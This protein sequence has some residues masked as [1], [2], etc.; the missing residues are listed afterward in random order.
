MLLSFRTKYHFGYPYNLKFEHE[1][2]FPF[3]RFSI[4]NLGDPFVESNYGVHS[5]MFEIE[6]LEFYA[7]LWKI[8]RN[9][10]FGYVTCSGT[11]GNLHGLY[12]GR[13]CLNN[14]ILYSSVESHYSVFKAARFYKIDLVPIPTLKTGEIN[15]EV[16]ET[17]L[18][19]NLDR[20]VLLNANVG[21]TMKGKK[22]K[23]N[24]NSE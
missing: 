1:E 20:D 9:E 4:N 11:E 3:L 19:K 22:K 17:E 8:K 13:E 16:F 18:K 24:Y 5:R 14:P 12:V 6:V 21:T 23:K 10:F 15:Y 7:A 2:L